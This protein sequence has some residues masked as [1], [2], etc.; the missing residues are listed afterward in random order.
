MPTPATALLSSLP[1]PAEQVAEILDALP[2]VV[3]VLRGPD[4]V[5]ELAN[6]PFRRLA[7]RR[8]LL[9]FPAGEVFDQP[10]NRPLV[11]LLDEVFA[12]GEPR[13][14][15]ETAAAVAAEAGGE[16]DFRPAW[17]DFVL[18]P[19]CGGTGDVEGVLV[20]AVDVS[21]QVRTRD[22]LAESEKR[23]RTLVDANLVGVVIAD[24]ECIVE[25]N[26]ALLR[27]IGADRAELEAGRVRWRDITPPEFRSPDERALSTLLETGRVGPYEKEFLDASGRRV[28]VLLGAALLEREPFRCVAFILDLSERRAAER[29]RETL[30]ARERE[31]RREAELAAG[32]IARLQTVTAA[33][34]AAISAE[35][36]GRMVVEEAMAA[37][38]AD[39]GLIAE[40][41]DH[42]AVVAHAVG[43]PADGLAPWRRFP[44][45]EAGPLTDAVRSGEPV[46]ITG[47]PDWETRYPSIAETTADFPALAGVP[48]V[49]HG[50]AL[51]AMALSFRAPRR[52]TAADRSFLVAL[53]RQAAQ[54]L[55][56][57][58]LYEERAY[59]ART[60]QEG[61]L[62]AHLSAV[63]GLD[64][65]VRYHSISDGGH[66]G[67]DFYD[68][69]DVAY[70]RWLVAVG[71]VCGKGTAAAVVTGLA[72]HT[73]RAIAMRERHPSAMLAF[74]NEALRRQV[75]TPGFCTV[76]CATL[77]PAEGGGFEACVASGGHPYPLLARAEGG[78]E[79]VPVPG[80][81]LGV[82]RVPRLDQVSVTL[83]PGDVL[84]FYTDGVTDARS[85]SGERFGEARLRAALAAARGGDVEAIASAIDEAVRSWEPDRP[86]DDRA[87]VVL[88]VLPVEAA[89]AA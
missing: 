70:N 36:V 18:L 25:A 71:D 37:L 62:P 9:G 55:E 52:F 48:F 81:L 74:L 53:G 28:P 31:A 17:F 73:L 69:F 51:G 32:R 44:L 12:T 82:E 10:E 20:H 5:V 30:L 29:E 7:G 33:L 1:A 3:G 4:H 60:L 40:V 66:V 16:G 14:G 56:R 19:L 26:D 79:D 22:L 83:R 27:T 85:P 8:P 86:R 80:T 64:V 38:G 87:I 58:R 47:Q 2:A 54:A 72:R 39:A 63:P 67:G 23:L 41:A 35:D 89:A 49:F 13:S 50:R 34:S 77:M 76:S 59:V 21:R 15:V 61:L 45:A 84:V 78:V 42:E 68:L 43:Y 46:L 65:A 57:A 88:R 6:P 24:G 11:A 75:T